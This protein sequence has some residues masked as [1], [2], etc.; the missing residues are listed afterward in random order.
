MPWNDSP[1]FDKM[2]SQDKRRLY[3]LKV[4][5]STDVHTLADMSGFNGAISKSDKI[6]KGIVM[7]LDSGESI[8]L[9]SL[10]W[11]ARFGSLSFVSQLVNES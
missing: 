4:V 2:R 3:P 10:L 8:D 5:V 1:F 6:E 7:G 11:G 9:Y